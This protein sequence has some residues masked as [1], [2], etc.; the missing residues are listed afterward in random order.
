M[1]IRKLVDF[2]VNASRAHASI[3]G[4]IDILRPTG[5]G[6]V[7]SG[8]EIQ[9]L[10]IQPLTQEGQSQMRRSASDD[11]MGRLQTDSSRQQPRE[12]SPVAARPDGIQIRG[13]MQEANR[14]INHT[15]QQIIIDERQLQRQEE[16]WHQHSQT[17]LG[18]AHSIQAP[19]QDVTDRLTLNPYYPFFDQTML[20]LF[21][22]GEMPD[23][24][25]LD[26]D[27]GSL[28]FFELEG[29]KPGSTD[30]GEE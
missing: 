5:S 18:F 11:R 12:N 30:P 13:Y 24:S 14:D 29:W 21:P 9:D 23:L 20:N 6:F 1:E 22:N 8:D 7:D 4:F 10:G 27:L 15:S 2:K 17:D 28:D 25:Q 3:L 16:L 19:N 26:A